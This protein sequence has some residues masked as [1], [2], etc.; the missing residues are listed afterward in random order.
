MKCNKILLKKYYIDY[1]F[2][3][4]LSIINM[5]V[6]I[7]GTI[8]TNNDFKLSLKMG[9]QKKPQFSLFIFNELR[10]VSWKG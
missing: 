3:G 4:I 5:L 6:A 2:G 9:D 10:E 7:S 1:P 8:I